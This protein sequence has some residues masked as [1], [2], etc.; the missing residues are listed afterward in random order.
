MLV[1]ASNAIQ[2]APAAAEL[3]TDDRVLRVRFSVLCGFAKLASAFLKNVRTGVFVS[4][5]FRKHYLCQ[6]N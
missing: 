4:I 3:T 1:A 6:A 5:D 2:E